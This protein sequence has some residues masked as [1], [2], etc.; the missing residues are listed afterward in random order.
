MS[1]G[2]L[3]GLDG[4]PIDQA[5]HH[6]GCAEV[7]RSVAGRIDDGDLKAAE[8]VLVI[9]IME[10]GARFT[11]YDSGQ[12]IETTLFMLECERADLIDRARQP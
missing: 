2:D 8:H 12:T 3:V 11:A 9:V 10:D 1:K 5:P 7:L 4:K 6:A